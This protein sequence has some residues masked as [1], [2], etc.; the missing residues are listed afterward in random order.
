[1]SDF[2][3][4]LS[5]DNTNPRYEYPATDEIPWISK[6][7]FT[8]RTHSQLKQAMKEFKTT[9]YKYMRSGILG[10]RKQMCINCEV[11]NHP[12]KIDFMC[13][14]KVKRNVCSFFNKGEELKSNKSFMDNEINGKVLDIEDLVALGTEKH[15]CPYYMSQHLAENADIVFS[16]YN[17]VLDERIRRNETLYDIVKNGIIVIDEAHNIPQLCEDLASV[18]FTYDDIVTA[19]NDVDCVSELVSNAWFISST[20]L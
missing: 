20:I 4:M 6:I 10:S 13:K 11:K 9:R 8:S 17:Y 3:R 16:P 7:I 1:M 19:L 5:S 18:D 12:E 15:F 14:S 2:Q